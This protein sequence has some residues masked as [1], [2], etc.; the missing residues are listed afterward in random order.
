MGNGVYS[1]GMKVAALL[2]LLA[3]L[4]AH[5][6]DPAAQARARANVLSSFPPEIAR[7]AGTQDLQRYLSGLSPEQQAAA[8]RSLTA[9]E[10]DLKKDPANL[11]VLGQVYAGLGKVKEARAAAE[12]LKRNNPNDPEADRLMRWVIGQEKL[13]R[14]DG[15]GAPGG[16]AGAPRAMAPARAGA[17]GRVNLS[18]FESQIQANFDRGLKSPEFSRTMSDA[19]AMD[20]G[21]LRRHNIFF[22]PAP[23][24]QKDAVVVDRE[25]ETGK[26]V[27]SIRRDALESDGDR[28]ARAAAQIANGVRNAQTLRDHEYLGRVIA[29]ARGW[30]SGGRTHKELAP[31]DQPANLTNSPE[32]AIMVGRM[33]S[34]RQSYTYDMTKDPQGPVMEQM[35]LGQTNDMA[36]KRKKDDSDWEFSIEDL[37]AFVVRTSGRGAGN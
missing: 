33:M 4:P 28:V 34:D 13:P 10:A 19:G 18:P 7:G 14:R 6:G 29:I 35:A 17:G 30:I 11:P 31:N 15:G 2:T 26:Y 16:E 24:D 23:A 9:K 21:N 12:Q 1:G 3:A 36:K 8:L 32:R 22:E 5:A 37:V 25:K 27:I 20:V